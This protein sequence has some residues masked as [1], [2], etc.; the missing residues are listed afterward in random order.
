MCCVESSTSFLCRST[1]VSSG[2]SIGA[3][4]RSVPYKTLMS[5]VEFGGLVSALEV[6]PVFM[7]PHG[8]GLNLRCTNLNMNKQNS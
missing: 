7:L 3:T 8:E 6:R 5:A 1:N 4:P 2:A